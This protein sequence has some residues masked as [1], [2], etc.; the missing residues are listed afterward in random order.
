MLDYVYGYDDLVAQFVAQL[1]PATRERGFG[2]C[3][4]FG[5][6]DPQGRMV[7]GMVYHNYD[8]SSGVIEMS[9]AAIPGQQWLS[10]ETIRRMYVYPFLQLD[11]Q[12]VLMRVDADDQRLLRQLAAL[13]YG[14]LR[15]P[16][17]LWRD[18]DAVVGLLTREAWEQNKFNKR[19]GHHLDGAR[20]AIEEAA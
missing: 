11:C 18:K 14:F 9:G 16:G 19:F 13:N 20:P 1:I 5:V 4:A 8:P 10:R 3:K 12:M 15:I 6:V 2:A 17:L 7:A